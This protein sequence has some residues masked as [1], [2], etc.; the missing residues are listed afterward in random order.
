M[1]Y[2][3]TN[4]V[5]GPTIMATNLLS[6]SWT[7]EYMFQGCSSLKSVKIYATGSYWDDNST[8]DWMDGVPS[9]GTFYYNGTY[10][11]HDTSHIPEGWTITPFT[12]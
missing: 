8:I 2:N 10:T 9:T 7:A 12:P 4:L 1:F 5:G 6:T 3:C 11:G